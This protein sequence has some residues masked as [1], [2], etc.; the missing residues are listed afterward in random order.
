MNKITKHISTYLIF[1]ITGLFIFTSC[2][3][4]VEP[5]TSPPTVVITSPVEDATLSN[6]TTIRVDATDDTGVEKV[7][8]LI[9]GQIIGTD[10]EEP[11]EHLWQIGRAHV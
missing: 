4:H 2:N 11:W 1:I 9:D 8:F 6:A 5:D 3:D 7:D 10:T